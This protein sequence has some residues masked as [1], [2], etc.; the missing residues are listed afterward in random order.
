MKHKELFPYFQ[1][2]LPVICLGFLRD[3]RIPPT[4][5]KCTGNWFGEN[6][7][8]SLVCVVYGARWSSRTRT[9]WAC[10]RA[11][12]LK[13][14]WIFKKDFKQ[15][16]MYV[17]SQGAGPDMMDIVHLVHCPLKL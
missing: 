14:N 2:V 8:S 3:L 17:W 11:V 13:K 12:S 16:L 4:L 5:H 7:K 10:F 1:Y 9:Q 15:W 6:V